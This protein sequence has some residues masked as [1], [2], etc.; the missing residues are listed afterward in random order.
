VQS[1][2][3]AYITTIEFLVFSKIT[4]SLPPTPIHNVSIH[5]DVNVADPSYNYPDNVDILSEEKRME[6]NMCL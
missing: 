6:H 3:S 1:L 4:G 2:N 5:D